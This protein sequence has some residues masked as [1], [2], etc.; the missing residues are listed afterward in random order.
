MNIL[1]NYCIQCFH[2]RNNIIGEQTVTKTNP[3]FQL[4]FN[5]RSCDPR[6]EPSTSSPASIRTGTLQHT[7]TKENNY[8]HRINLTF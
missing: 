2:F 8:V 3:L 7:Y 6:T 5:M 1:E 4:A